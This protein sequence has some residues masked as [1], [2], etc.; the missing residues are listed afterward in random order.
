MFIHSNIQISMRIKGFLTGIIVGLPIYLIFSCSSTPPSND[1]KAILRITTSIDSVVTL[2]SLKVGAERLDQYLAL[3]KNK[4]VG[5]VVNHTAMVNKTHLV[6]TLLSLGVNIRKIYAPEHGF[7][8][9]A[10]AGEHVASYT[11]KKTGIA[12]VSLYGSNKK[13]LPEQ[14][15][16]VDIM[17]YDIQDVGA[18]F[19]TYISTMY[20]VMESCAENNKQLL[21]LDRP[22][23]NGD[24]VDGP[25]LDM[26]LKSF[27]GM[28]PLPIV[29]GLTVGELA[30]MIQGEKWLKDSLKCNFTVVSVLNY[31][32]NTEYIL[33]IKPSPNMPNN[34]A[35][36]LY[37]SLGLFEGTNVSVG[38]G[39]YFPFQVLGSP[40][41]TDTAFSF[42]PVS[43]DGMSKDPMHMNKKCY[44]FDLRNVVYKKEVDLSYVIKMYEL[45]NDKIGYF[46]KNNFF[47]KL[48][49]TITLKQQLIEKKS[50]AEIKLTW[51]KDLLV[52]KT[53]RKKYLL[54]TDFE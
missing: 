4:K 47:D 46:G 11:D 17:I 13:P 52:Y 38:R 35:I 10:D 12:V 3:L 22:N 9:T 28:L 41:T 16:D 1:A 49:G 6:D 21:I 29:H 25:I 50:A 39:T 14:L 23:P 26:K 15:A 18:R 48:A 34:Q 33:P 24:Y 27:V 44:G 7:R 51:Q 45:T 31:T 19:F 53:M 20:L 37:P 8:G 42:T 54:Y 5:M 2:Q 40:F 36:R 43:I 30:G 32:H